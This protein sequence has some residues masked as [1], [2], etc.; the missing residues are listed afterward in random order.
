MSRRKLSSSY[1][2]IDVND[3]FAVTLAKRDEWSLA[4]FLTA[5][6]NLSTATLLY[7]K[8]RY[9]HSVFFLQQCVECIVKGILIENGLIDN[10]RD[11]NHFPEEA[12]RDFFKMVNSSSE[13]NCA[14][15]DK[16]FSSEMD[17]SKRMSS[18]AEIVNVTYNQIKEL[19]NTGVGFSVSKQAYSS[20]GLHRCSTEEN[21]DMRIWDIQLSQILLYTF[22]KLLNPCQQ[23]SR[24]PYKSNG[25]IVLPAMIYDDDTAEELGKVIQWIHYIISKII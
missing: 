23:D 17:F 14:Y 13:E 5:N 10:P 22:G 18:A 8:R 21:A 16:V 1:T 9:S 4:W 6:E 24:Y 12:F 2:T 11:L 25:E 19:K 3:T 20:L 15:I 7:E